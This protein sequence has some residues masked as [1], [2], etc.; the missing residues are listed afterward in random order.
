LVTPEVIEKIKRIKQRDEGKYFSIIAPSFWWVRDN[1]NVPNDFEK[2]WKT[3]KSQYPWR[4]LTILLPLQETPTDTI[5]FSLIWRWVRFIDHRFQEIVTKLWKPFI[6]TSANLSGQ[7]NITHP[8]QLLDTQ[9]Q[10]ID[11]CIDEGTLDRPASV[12][13][14]RTTQQLIRG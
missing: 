5:D 8:D 4:W 11:Y 10:L 9:K 1:Y 7:P 14:D 12:I 3:Y 6:T 13:I 2:Q